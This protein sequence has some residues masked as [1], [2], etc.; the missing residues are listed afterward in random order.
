ML[1]PCSS[2]R[3]LKFSPPLPITA[4]TMSEGTSTA[5]T[6]S[7]SRRRSSTTALR[8]LSTHAFGPES[9]TVPSL[10][11]S[12]S[13]IAP[14]LS[15]WMRLMVAPPLPSSLCFCSGS[16]LTTSSTRRW[17]SSISRIRFSACST[18]GGVPAM[19]SWFADFFSSRAHP[20]DSCS[21]AMVAP[22]RPMSRPCCISSTCT[23]RTAAGPKPWISAAALSTASAVPISRGPF[24]PEARTITCCSL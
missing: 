12:R 24:P 20:V 2:S 18:I 7:A 22:L 17:L 13:I 6:L 9:V 1:T 14:P 3:R 15:C 23:L 11:L 16:N 4:S 10:P 8:A 21:C 19:I 5:R